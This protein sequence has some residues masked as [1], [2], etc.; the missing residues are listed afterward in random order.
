MLSRGRTFCL[1]VFCM[2]AVKNDI[3]LNKCEIRSD[4]GVISVDDQ[5]YSCAHLSINSLNHIDRFFLEGYAYVSQ[6][7][8]TLL[9][10]SDL[11]KASI[12]SVIFRAPVKPSRKSSSVFLIYCKRVFILSHYCRHTTT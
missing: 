11:C 9:N 7:L 6:E 3:G 1:A 2:I 4:L 8:G 10:E 5:F 12:A